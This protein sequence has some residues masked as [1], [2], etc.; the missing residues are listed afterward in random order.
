[1]KCRRL[2]T[3]RSF[4]AS[5]AFPV[6]SSAR[7]Q[8]AAVIIKKQKVKLKKIMTKTTLVRKAQM[9]KMKDKTP[10]KSSQKAIRH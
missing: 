6:K 7:A 10:M 3:T 9:R 5:F 1:M 2:H 8:K 4:C